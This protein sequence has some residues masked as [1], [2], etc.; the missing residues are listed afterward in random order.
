MRFKTFF[1]ENRIAEWQTRY[2]NYRKL[3]RLAKDLPKM[4][5]GDL[6]GSED[7]H[8]RNNLHRIV[9][10]EEITDPSIPVEVHTFWRMMHEQ[11]HKVNEFFIAKLK[12]FQLRFEVLEDQLVALETQALSAKA[13]SKAQR[14]LRRAFGEHYRSLDML[15]KYGDLNTGA[16]ERLCQLHD[17]QSNLRVFDVFS[18]FLLKQQ[19]VDSPVLDRLAEQSESL[20][21]NTWASGNLD[22]AV[23]ELD[24]QRIARKREKPQITFFLGFLLGLLVLG[25]VAII[26]VLAKS[27]PSGYQSAE[28]V[29]LIY[30]TALL[31]LLLIAAWGVNVILFD[32]HNVNHSYILEY[33]TNKMRS[34]TELVTM[35]LFMLV[36]WQLSVLGYVYSESSDSFDLGVPGEWQPLILLGVLFVLWLWPF[37][38]YRDTRRWALVTCLRVFTSPIFPVCFRDFYLADNFTSLSVMFADYPFALCFYTADASRD[39][40]HCLD[41]V[42]YWGPVLQSLPFVWRG[43]QCARRLAVT[44]KRIHLANMIK[45]LLVL[46]VIVFFELDNNLDGA[47]YGVYTGLLVPLAVISYTYR[48][49]WDLRRDWGLFDRSQS[50]FPLR[51]L[52][53]YR[54]KV[55]YILAVIQNCILRYAWVFVLC[56]DAFD[57]PFSRTIYNSVFVLIEFYRRFVW[58]FFRMENEQVSN[59]GEFRAVRETP[60]PFTNRP[61]AKSMRRMEVTESDDGFQF[62]GG[63]TDGDVLSD[64]EGEWANLDPRSADHPP[65]SH[66]GGSRSNLYRQRTSITPL[67]PARPRR[68]DYSSGGGGGGGRDYNGAYSSGLELQ[69]MSMMDEPRVEISDLDN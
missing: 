6:S 29:F 24:T 19:F 61:R 36:L 12:V 45:Y 1:Y 4:R 31:S 10:G 41:S 8:A 33:K 42:K 37:K 59:C 60:I 35:A 3:A 63:E 30:R 2:L 27:D 9:L 65:L 50:A 40:T 54:Y 21:A 39:S 62:S 22:E 23:I 58:N 38:P 57:V 64:W 68:S 46:P 49:Y 56:Y 48:L 17:L 5:D 51:A 52:L 55:I 25:M 47:S 20:F 28:S 34:G 32:R 44:R 66:G 67:A 13:K 14:V 69:S 16:C 53:L 26:T 11:I 7:S 43:V 18:S 15:T